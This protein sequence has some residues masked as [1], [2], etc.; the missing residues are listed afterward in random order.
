MPQPIPKK[1][2]SALDT[3]PLEVSS[4]KYYVYGITLRS[5]IPLALPTDGSGGLAQIE[6][7]T[8]PVS[9]FS[10]ARRGL[11]ADPASDSWYRFG[12]LPDHS[13]YV[14]W[15]GVGEFLVSARGNQITARRFNEASLES[16]QVYLLGQAL[17][18]AL[19]KCG[20]EPLHATTVVVNGEAVA[21][22]GESGFGKS[23]L[24]ACFLD[25]GYG[26][27]T[28]DLLV[29]KRDSLKKNAGIFMAYPGPPRIKLFPDVARRFLGNGFSGVAMNSET[30]KLV[31]PLGAAKLSL[32]PV[33]LKAL[34]SL[35][36][37]RPGS[38]KQPIRIS[39]LSP[40]EGFMTLVK[41]T[42]NSRI[43]HSARL[44][45]QFRQTAQVVSTMPVRTLS[46][47]R[48]LSQ[49]PAVRDAILADLSSASERQVACG[50]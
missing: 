21:F 46:Y 2:L 45:R 32:A 3:E 6:L 38:R 35:A 43:V 7:R 4:R 13:S 47:P 44:E 31:L 30:R 16:F 1:Q 37:P 23:T 26:I 22:L 36:A 29:L 5:E 28:D 14:R 12:G 48:V 18:F 9:Y 39:V 42:F 50:D 34:Y 27:L 41:N 10:D 19:V 11:I 33:S 8:A 49:L 24:A 15:E 20:F 40:R 17:S 25:A